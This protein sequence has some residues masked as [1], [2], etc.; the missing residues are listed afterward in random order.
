[1]IVASK[2]EI[3][4]V[5]ADAVSVHDNPFKMGTRGY[6]AVQDALFDRFM[7]TRPERL[8]ELRELVSKTGGPVLDGTPESLG[9]LDDWLSVPV[10]AGSDWD[11][12]VDWLPVWTRISTNPEP[13]PGGLDRAVLARL[14]ERVALYYADVVIGALPGSKWVCWRQMEF[15]VIRTGDFLVDIGTFPIPCDALGSALSAVG[16][17]WATLRDPSDPEYRPTKRYS[18]PSEFEKHLSYRE[19]RLAEGKPLDF[20][21]APTG[22][23]AG[24]NR[25]PYK[26]SRIK[27]AIGVRRGY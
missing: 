4:R 12:G 7:A 23:E 15:N 10:Y 20:Q 24:V 16:G 25:G 13:L 22:D 19:K 5:I 9:P 21:A 3:A 26:G 14:E 1:L 6:W 18:L 27:H 8:E 17:V 2:A 11:D